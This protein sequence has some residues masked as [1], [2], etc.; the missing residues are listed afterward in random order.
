[1]TRKYSLVIEGDAPGYSA[2]VP[3]LPTIL[4]T[5]RSVEELTGSAAEAIRVYWES[6]HADRSP[7]S[8]LREIEVELPV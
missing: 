8:T 1:M 6:T 7:T 5:G 3:E 4:V 2:Y